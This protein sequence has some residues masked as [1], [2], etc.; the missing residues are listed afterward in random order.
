L[1]RC[2]DKPKKAA[3][4]SKVPNAKPTPTE[5]FHLHRQAQSQRARTLSM[6]LLPFDADHLVPLRRSPDV[7]E[8]CLEA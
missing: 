5:A 4:A 2:A 8:A 3:K 1:A 6:L 7:R